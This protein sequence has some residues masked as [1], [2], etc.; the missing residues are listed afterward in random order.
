MYIKEME[1]DCTFCYN[2]WFMESVQTTWTN[3]QYDIYVG[4][5]RVCI[6]TNKGNSLKSVE[7]GL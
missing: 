2:E 6:V 1:A 4:S 5:K 3:M 7:R